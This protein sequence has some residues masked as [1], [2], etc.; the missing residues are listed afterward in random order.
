MKQRSRFC[1]PL[2]FSLLA[3][4]IAGL[5]SSNAYASDSDL[6][7]CRDWN[8]VYA[9]AHF[10]YG[11]GDADMSLTPLPD[12]ATFANLAPQTLSPYV[13][14]VLGGVQLGYNYHKKCTVIGVETD[15]SLS[16]LSGTER[17][18]PIIQNNGTPFPG[19]GDYL[20]DHQDTEW[21]G[22]VR[23]RLG[24]TP[25]SKLLIYGTGGMA[26]GRVNYE[27]ETEFRPTGTENYPASFSKT[28]VGWTAGC[29]VEYA[30]DTRWSMRFEYLYYNLG[31]QSIIADPNP[32]YPPFQVGYEWHTSAH[33]VNLGLN[34]KL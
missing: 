6:S 11:W 12:A 15:F 34:Y 10:G 29:G 13:K 21:V 8:G 19:T 3:F 27:A 20:R 18:E 28:K 33:T 23:L 31:K 1:N 25:S 4:G 22:T 5:V 16:D 24:Y 9:G 14:G 30:L 2:K 7:G 26:Y 32:V 17:V